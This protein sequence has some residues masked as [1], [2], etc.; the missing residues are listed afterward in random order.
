MKKI[1]LVLICMTSMNLLTMDPKKQG[2]E[3]VKLVAVRFTSK[4]AEERALKY[5]ATTLPT[6]M[7]EPKGKQKD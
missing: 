7:K 5:L 6:E 3:E 1:I 2:K 4:K